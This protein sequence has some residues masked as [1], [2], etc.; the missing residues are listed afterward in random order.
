M[1][2]KGDHCEDQYKW[3]TRLAVEVAMKE[4]I[5]GQRQ[6]LLHCAIDT[7][8]RH[9]QGKERPVNYIK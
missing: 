9:T 7:F 4:R 8:I 5:I 2:S 3:E 6:R 1:I